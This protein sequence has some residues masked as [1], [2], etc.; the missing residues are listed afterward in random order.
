MSL[1]DLYN[2]LKVYESEVQKKS[3][4]NSQNMTLI[5][6]TKH[7]SGN[8]EVNIASGSTASINVSNT[9]A[10]IG[11]A[12]IN[13]ENACAYIASQSSGSQIKFEDINQIDEDDVGRWDWSYMANDEENHALIADEETP[14]EFALMAKT[15]AESEVF[16][17]SLCSK[18]WLAQV[19][20][21]LA[22]HR[23]QELKY[24]VNVTVL[25]FFLPVPS[26][27]EPVIKAS[28]QALIALVETIDNKI[29]YLGLSSANLHSSGI[30]F[31]LAMGTSFTGSGNFL[32]RQWELF[33]TGEKIKESE[34]LIDQLDLPCDI[35]SEYD[36]FNSQDFSRDDD[37]P[38]PD[39]EDKVFNPGILIHEKSVSIITRVAQEKKL[40]I[41]FASL[42]FEDFNP[43]FYEP[44][45][46]KEVPNSMR[47]LPFSS[48]NKKKVF[49]PGIYTSKKVKIDDPNITMKEY[50]RLEEE[51]ACRRGK[52]N[53]WETAT[54]GK[55]WYDEDVHDL[56]SVE[57][58][59]PAIVFNDTLTSDEALSCEPT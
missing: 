55:I 53:N 36:S 31:L 16:D 39:N 38:S 11:V 7:S 9:S 48:E 50:I 37:F 49:K 17:N 15:S 19:E 47:L 32:H 42:L 2:H 1:D 28:H 10:N 30:S 5:S 59:F 46:F 51:R 20:A 23:N 34:L 22:E 6:S 8:E 26:L 41:S 35:L 27:A 29:Y 54:Y 13:Q 3:E 58:G 56:R 45:V 14:I 4:L 33:L 57:T 24:L 52:V 40:A 44:L 18:A 43:P 25:P 12:S 21:R